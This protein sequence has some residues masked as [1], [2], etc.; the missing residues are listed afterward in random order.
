MAHQAGA[1]PGSYGMKPLEILPLPSGWSH[2]R[3]TP[4]IKFTGSHLYT[5]VERGTVTV[6]CL[7]HED[8]TS[9]WPE[10]VPRPLDSWAH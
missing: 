3:V 8:K 6:K 4:S 5:W 1:Y 10:L 7:A 2:H 9:P